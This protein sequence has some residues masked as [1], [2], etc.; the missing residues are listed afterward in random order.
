VDTSKLFGVLTKQAER[1]EKRLK[2]R[3]PDAISFLSGSGIS[4]GKIRK[5]AAR[6]LASGVLGGTLLLAAPGL[7]HLQPAHSSKFANLSLVEREK[8]FG[9]KMFA[10]LPKPGEPQNSLQ[11][12]GVTSLI[13]EYWGIDARSSLDGERLNHTWG[14]MGAEQHL[15]RY[16]GDTADQH[17]HLQEK[18][19]TP[20]KGAWGYFAH[21][22]SELT[23]DLMRKE[24]YYV[25]VQT[26]Y[27]TDWEKRLPYLR[28]WYKYRK[29]IVINPKNGKSI[30]CDIADSGPS[31][32]TGKQFGGSPEVMA[33][34]GLNT[35][36]QKGAVVLYFVSDP[37]N[38][39]PLGPIQ[40]T[41]NATNILASK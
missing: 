38:S 34:L 16:P 10:Y 40:P 12:L 7:H 36:M 23:D 28:D 30:I 1:A 8:F 26:L 18:G 27:L 39:V 3:H 17:D 35:G 25:A 33:Y 29:V 15:P 21:S 5:H 22:K 20:G 9:Q 2:V 14:F 41:Q 6:L 32:Y 19:I 4:P 31:A 37:D 24:Q 11:E 13:H